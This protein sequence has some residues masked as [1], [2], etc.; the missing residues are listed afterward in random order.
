MNPP[1]NPRAATA[2]AEIRAYNAPLLVNPA[3]APCEVVI[4]Q[5]HRSDVARTFSE[6][7][8]EMWWTMAATISAAAHAAPQ[9][10]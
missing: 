8:V 4:A 9:G 6:A 1:P 10:E 2:A 3:L 7:E 5:W